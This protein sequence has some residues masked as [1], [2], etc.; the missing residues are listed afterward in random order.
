MPSR[1]R[2]GDV[3]IDQETFEL[4]RGGALTAVEPQVFELVSYLARNPGRLVTKDELIKAP[5][6]GRSV[7]DATLASRIKSARRA[8]G[9]DA[10]QQ[11]W[12]KTVHG[13]GVRFVGEVEDDSKSGAPGLPA[14]D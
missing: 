8:T 2:F 9:D 5:W 11:K 13:R 10:E 1:L 6:H 12:T 3:E 7:S 4:R 14:S